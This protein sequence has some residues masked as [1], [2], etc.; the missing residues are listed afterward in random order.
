MVERRRFSDRERAALYLAADGRCSGCGVELQPGW[1]ADHEVPWSRGGP[2]DVINGQAL[3]PDCN[4]KKAA[5]VVDLRRWQADAIREFM[6]W[7]PEGDR[8]FLV[9]ATPGAG[10]T[11][12]SIDIAVRLLDSGRI[13]RIVIAVPTARL[14]AQW[15]EEFDE[16]GI[17]INPL[18]RAADGRLAPDVRGCAA[19][20]AEI[21]NQP[22]N[23]RRLVGDVPTLFIGDEVHHCARERNWGRGLSRAA[24]PAVRKLFL[25][26]TPFRSDNNEI[27]GVNYVDGVG[28][29]DFRY[30]YRKALADRVVRAVFFPRRGGTAEW[31]WHGELRSATFEEALKDPEANRRLRTAL[32]PNGQWLPSVLADADRQLQEVRATDPVAAG[33][34]FCETAEDAWATAAIL[35]G[36]GRAPVVAISEEIDSDARIAAF[37][38]SSEPWM[39]SIR[40]VS[41]GVDIPRL[42]VGVYATPWLTEMFFRQVVGRLVRTHE[43]EDDPTAYLFIP[44]DGRLRTLAETIKD[45]RDHVLD[46]QEAEQLD[47]FD[48]EDGGGDRATSTFRPVA[49]TATDMGTIVDAETIAPGELAHAQEVKL[50]AP[51]TASLPTELVAKLL[52]NAGT[53]VTTPEPNVAEVPAG[54]PHHE[55]VRDL[56]KL[57]NTS[58]ARISKAYGIDY[59]AVG[60]TLN[61]AVGLPRRNGV[62][63]ASEEQLRQ[64]LKLG[65]EWLATGLP[66]AGGHGS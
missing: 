56:R 21:A 12:L 33:I 49:A 27:P 10:K 4:R 20:Y 25:S 30:G 15:A 63:K 8:G 64:R 23:Y 11:R 41:E 62:P 55:R 43:K 26:G 2:T 57:N 1:H 46:Q 60:G 66:P 18:W 35:R 65:A 54:R 24:G 61:I 38:G 5:R 19:T 31:E 9:E 32:S 29:P 16:Y 47:L 40:K 7:T 44:D 48:S 52:R 37:R 3:C 22:E 39:V 6:L 50:R 53:P 42:R 17:N 58:V 45:D 51:E 34:V 59:G 13:E 28:V 36:I 14:E